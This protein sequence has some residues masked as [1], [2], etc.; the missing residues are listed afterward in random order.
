[1]VAVHLPHNGWRPRPAQRQIWRA[2][3]GGKKRISAICHRRFGKDDIALHATAIAAHER[4]ADYWHCLPQ[5]AQARKAIWDAV[6]PHTGRRRIDEAFPHHLRAKTRE[7]DMYI[8]FK[9]GSGWRVVGSD[10]PNSLVGTAPAGITFSEWALSNP[11]SWAYLAPILEENDGWAFFITTPRGRNHAHGMHKMAE[12]TEG[13]AAFH[14]GVKESGFPLA[15]VEQARQEYREIFGEDQADALIDQEYY[16]SWDAAILGAYYGKELARLLALGQLTQHFAVEPGYPIHR[17]WDLGVG[18]PCAIWFFQV[19]A[20][21]VRVLFYYENNGA[22]FDHFAHVIRNVYNVRG[23]I[24]YVPHDAAV[25]VLTSH[26]EPKTRLE[27]MVESG[28]NPEIVDIHRLE[29]GIAAVRRLLPRCWFHP[30]CE[31]GLEKLR[32][33]RKEWDDDNRVFKNK[34]LHDFSSHCAD[35]FRTLAMAYEGIAPS[36][37]IRPQKQLVIATNPEMITPNQVTMGDLWDMRTDQHEHPM[38]Y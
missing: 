9:N 24:D 8:K 10:D 36:Q 3:E 16:C 4:V 2:I 38:G 1:M 28:L 19:V 32:H 12:H 14:I 11:S 29:D 37:I 34:P 35:G 7:Q 20:G 33:Y 25:K 15:R 26:E 18:D 5:Y 30:R 23:G 13:W 21:Q 17:A 31:P 27:W 22:G 6:N